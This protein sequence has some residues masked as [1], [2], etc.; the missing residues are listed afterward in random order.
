MSA[1]RISSLGN[2]AQSGRNRGTQRALSTSPFLSLSLAKFSLQRKMVEEMEC[3][4]LLIRQASGCVATQF[5]SPLVSILIT[6]CTT[7]ILAYRYILA[8]RELAV[9]YRV[10][11]P[12]ELSAHWHGKE[13]HEVRGKDKEILEGQA[14]G[15]RALLLLV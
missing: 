7:T 14:N 8:R 9:D 11:A 12:P 4:E 5:L 6:I 15:V 13:W 1:N 3:F 2:F 10:P